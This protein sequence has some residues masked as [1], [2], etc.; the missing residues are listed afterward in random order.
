M[1]GAFKMSWRRIACGCVGGR[2]GTKFLLTMPSF[3]ND[4]VRIDAIGIA[5]DEFQCYAP[6]NVE[7]DRVTLAAFQ[8]AEVETG[9]I[10]VFGRVAS[11]KASRRRKPPSAGSSESVLSCPVRT[12]LADPYA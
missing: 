8:R 7:V 1:P 12:A 10:H 2:A 5:V 9:D 4:V 11:F 3:L 6:R